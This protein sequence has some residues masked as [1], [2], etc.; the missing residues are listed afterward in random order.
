MLHC[1]RSFPKGAT[2]VKDG[3]RAHHL[4]DALCGVNSPT[5]KDLLLALTLAVNH[6][7][8]EHCPSI[9]VE[10][11]ASAP[12]TPLLR[13]DNEI[14]PIPVGTIGRRLDIEVVMLKVGKDM[15]IYL[16][17]YQFG[18]VCRV[19]LKRFYMHWTVL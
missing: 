16:G 18:L 4:I 1:L 17:D 14:R 11:I 6:W 10:Y 9:L 15:A 2:C 19:V 12:L 5:G 7:L 13:S 8:H 3:I